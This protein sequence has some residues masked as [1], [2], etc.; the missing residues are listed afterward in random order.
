MWSAWGI[1]LGRCFLLWKKCSTDL[2]DTPLMSIERMNMLL[3]AEYVGSANLN[4]M[5][6][7]PLV[8]IV[9]DA[10][11]DHGETKVVDCVGDM[12]IS[13]VGVPGS[14]AMSDMRLSMELYVEMLKPSGDLLE[15][16]KV[17]LMSESEFLL[18]MKMMLQWLD[19]AI[20][21]ICDGAHSIAC[22]IWWAL[23]FAIEKGIFW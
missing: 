13:S 21:N 4:R 19:R 9:G 8:S 7:G 23:I 17:G 16:V 18:W 1:L 3:R 10:W 22:L 14:W 2:Y 15:M 5:G 11:S 20:K 6:L 12:S